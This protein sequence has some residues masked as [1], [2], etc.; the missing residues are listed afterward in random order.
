MLTVAGI[1]VAVIA[2][3]VLVQRWRGPP[4]GVSFDMDDPRLEAAKVQARAELDRF[5]TALAAGAPGDTDFMLKFDL[6]HGRGLDHRESIWARDIARADGRI[7][8][9]LAN[10]P[11]DSAYR[12][13]D[14]VDIAPEAI[15]DWCFFR[16]DVAQGHFVTSLML[17]QLPERHARQGRKALGW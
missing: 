16:N 17:S 2:A 7:T 4:A 1:V 10:P 8:G 15:D 3:L 12:Q 5:W 6:C 13:G 14:M 11:R 9:R